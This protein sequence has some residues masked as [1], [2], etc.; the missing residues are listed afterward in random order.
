MKP[1]KSRSIFLSNLPYNSLPT[2]EGLVLMYILECC[3]W[4]RWQ[5][6]VREFPTQHP[7][8]QLPLGAI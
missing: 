5:Q 2:F 1:F 6:Y 3:G 4:R 7:P 8:A